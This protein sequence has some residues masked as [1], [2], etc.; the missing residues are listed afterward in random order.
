MTNCNDSAH[1]PHSPIVI[2]STRTRDWLPSRDGRPRI[3]VP[4]GPA[5][6]IALALDR[7]GAPYT[8]M[9]G[10]VA[11]VDVVATANGEAYI[12]PTLP[13][14]PLPHQLTGSAVILS[15]IMQEIDAMA[16]PPVDGI[17]AI[18]LQGFVREPGV[19][20]SNVRRRF[21]LGPLLR[22][23]D[24]VKAAERELALLDSDST[25]A[26]AGTALLVT[27]GTRDAR[28][29][30]DGCETRI[31]VRPVDVPYAIGAGDIFLAAMTWAL[32]RQRDH[33]EAAEGAARF[34]ETLLRE[35]ATAL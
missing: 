20:S 9:T 15:P 29:V 17:L 4:G 19:S 25:D 26:L 10:T 23:C 28:L 21:P 11:D 5:H 30:V 33:V 7:L 18:D 22:R 31:P 34:T 27:G 35:R 3:A 2:V 8:L 13:P 14:I 24:L 12:I 16:L 32:I 1:R 6:Y